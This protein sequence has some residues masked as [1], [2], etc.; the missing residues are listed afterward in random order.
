[1]NPKLALIVPV[2]KPGPLSEA[3]Q[4]R[5]AA[6]TRA[7]GS[8]PGSAVASPSNGASSGASPGAF[9]QSAGIVKGLGAL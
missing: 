4:A 7:L 3:G 1:M 8:R 2:T 5:L 9:G 6:W